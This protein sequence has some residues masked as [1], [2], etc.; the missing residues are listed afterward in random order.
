MKYKRR[1]KIITN[2]IDDDTMTSL[3]QLFL[4]FLPLL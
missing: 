4:P 2:F 1:T 3:M